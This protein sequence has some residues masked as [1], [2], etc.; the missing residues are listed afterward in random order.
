MDFSSFCFG[1]YQ[2]RNQHRTLAFN[3][4]NDWPLYCCELEEN[5]I[6]NAT[7]AAKNLLSEKQF[8]SCEYVAFVDQDDL[9]CSSATVKINNAISSGNFDLIFSNELIVNNLGEPEQVVVK[10]NFSRVVLNDI[11]YINHVTVSADN[12]FKLFS[13]PLHRWNSGPSVFESFMRYPIYKNI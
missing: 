4:L 5:G 6:V 2:N 9:L 7:I 10:G 1:N 3:T 12:I 8:E 11:N 13:T